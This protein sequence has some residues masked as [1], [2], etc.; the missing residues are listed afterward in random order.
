VLHRQ[1]P[2]DGDVR[3]LCGATPPTTATQPTP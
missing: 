1:Y 2:S 3:S